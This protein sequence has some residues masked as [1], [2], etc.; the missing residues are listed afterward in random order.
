MLSLYNIRLKDAAIMQPQEDI[1][2]NILSAGLLETGGTAT[3]KISTD[4]I[5]LVIPGRF[6]GGTTLAPKHAREIKSLGESD[7]TGLPL[8]DRGRADRKRKYYELGTVNV[9]E[10]HQTTDGAFE[11][12]ITLS[13]TGTHETH[14]RAMRTNAESV[15]TNLATGS[16]GLIAADHRA[17]KVRWFDAA[18]G[19][20]SATVQATAVGE[21][22]SVDRYDPTEP[23]FDDPT[24]LYELPFDREW[25]DD[26]NVWDDRGF[27]GKYFRITEGGQQYDT[28]QYDTAATGREA[29][30]TQWAHAYHPGYEF[31]GRAII[32]NRFLRL[33]F[34]EAAGNLIAAEYDANADAWSE[35]SISQGDYALFDAD[36]EAIGPAGVTAYTE[37]E[38][39]VSGD[40]D[41]AVIRVQRGL[42]RAT[43]RIPANANSIPSALETVLSPIA[44]DVTTDPQPTQTLVRRSDVK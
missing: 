7:Y 38:D 8:Y 42:D 14:W 25:R 13:E 9:D 6:D 18:N 1:S 36:I 24:L 28:T 11:Y 16:D 32:D 22:G 3:S 44:S 4:Q 37:W 43:I 12:T 21:K 35:I 40:I 41:A 34:D 29:T 27:D 30:A 31:D 2:A 15:G 10:A 23:S 17:S 26:V 19:T 33:T 39:T 5:D 20:E